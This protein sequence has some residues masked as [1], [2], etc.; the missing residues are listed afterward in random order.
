MLDAVSEQMVCL[1][2]DQNC[3]ADVKVSGRPRP[4][5][6]A[7]GVPARDPQLPKLVHHGRTQRRPAHVRQ[8]RGVG[9]AEGVPAQHAVGGAVETHDPFLA[10]AQPRVQEGL[11]A[12]AEQRLTGGAAVVVTLPNPRVW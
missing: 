3:V 4:A 5:A 11:E 8:G 9:L 7:A 10:L 12:D 2:H 1:S 6:N